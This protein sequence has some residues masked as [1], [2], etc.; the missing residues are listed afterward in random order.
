M[1]ITSDRCSPVVTRPAL[2]K[3]V[4]HFPA[5]GKRTAGGLGSEREMSDIYAAY[6]PRIA[7]FAI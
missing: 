3:D 1:R 4:F 2:A 7:P 6:S 5:M